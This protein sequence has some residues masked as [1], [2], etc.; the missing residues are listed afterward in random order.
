MGNDTACLQRMK[1]REGRIAL[2]YSRTARHVVIELHNSETC[3]TV[4]DAGDSA[5]GRNVSRSPPTASEVFP[6]VLVLTG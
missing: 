4:R 3:H 5:S 1:F 2:R 6:L